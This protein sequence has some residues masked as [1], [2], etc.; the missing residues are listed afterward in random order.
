ML[1]G[2]HVDE[3]FA[4]IADKVLLKRTGELCKGASVPFLGR[5]LRHEGRSISILAVRHYVVGMLT[6]MGLQNCKSSPTPGVKPTTS[7]LSAADSINALDTTE[8]KLY[9]RM[10]GMLLW[11]VPIRP[12]IN[13]AVKELSRSLGSPTMLCMGK[14][15][16]E[17]RYLRGT[18]DYALTIFPH[19]YSE[20]GS[21][22]ALDVRVDCGRWTV[23]CGL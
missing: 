18:L 22:V 10:T 7:L 15:K 8:A 23:D 17:L 20:K 11:L 4:A 19:H 21:Q 9:R 12:D 6:E 13:Y 3:L 16:H 2:L 14:L 5:L 1:V